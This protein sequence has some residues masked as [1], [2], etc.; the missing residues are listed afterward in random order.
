MDTRMADHARGAMKAAVMLAGL[1][2]ALSNPGYGG[3]AV[4][5]DYKIRPHDK[6]H[7]QVYEWP[8]LSSDLVVTGEGTIS[9]PIV[10]AMKAAG[11]SASD[12]A[13][14]ISAALQTR[15]KLHDAPY[16]M[17]EV[18][19]FQPFYILGETQRPGEYPYR[20]GMTVLMALSVSGGPTRPTDTAQLAFERDNALNR[21][22]L[23]TA[24]ARRQELQTRVGRLHAEL[25]GKGDFNLNG[26]GEPYSPELL[27]QERLILQARTKAF[28]NEI[29][30]LRRQVEFYSDEIQFLRARSESS[31]KQAASAVKE[32]AGLKGLKS[33][34]LV[35]RRGSLE[36]LVAQMEGDQREIDA[37]IVTAQRSIAQTEAQIGKLADERQKDLG[38]EL[39]QASAQ[40]NENHQQIVLNKSLLA[41]AETPG[42]LMGQLAQTNPGEGRLGFSIRRPTAGIMRE[43]PA[44]PDDP[45]EPGDVIEVKRYLS[46]RAIGADPANGGARRPQA[47]LESQ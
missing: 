7:T 24:E 5:A 46:D 23:A 38:Q 36:R 2:L 25:E 10:G 8:A 11:S 44:Q 41:A 17:V 13:R 39:R 14:L 27:A 30:A 22:N 20:P 42:S 4:A 47:A 19:Q 6:L 34:E 21:A 43:L 1:A 33:A 40:M 3:D 45:I 15:A 12:L 35:A 37:R 31:A 29:A 18:L 16:V 26:G 28:Q 9:L 32:M